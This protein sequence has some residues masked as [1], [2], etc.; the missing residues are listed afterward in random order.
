MTKPLVIV[1]SGLAGYT[2][3]REFRKLNSDQPLL[4]ITADGGESYSKPMLS[5]AFSAGKDKHALGMASAVQMAEKLNATVL[6]ETS[7][8][9]IDLH[10]RQLLLDGQEVVYDKLVL[11]LGASPLKLE[12]AGDAVGEVLQVNNLDDYQRFFVRLQTAKSVLVIGSGL[13]G[14]EFANDLALGGKQVTLVGRAER[15]LKRLLPAAIATHLQ[16]KLAQVGVVWRLSNQVTSINRA[17][18][19]YAVRLADGTSLQ[20]DLILSALGL[21]ANTTLAEQ[22]GLQT[23]RAICVDRLLCSSQDS[24]YAL[25][26]CAQVDGLHLPFV[27]PLMKSA[28]VLANTLAGTSTEVVYPAMPVAVKTKSVP[29]VVSPPQVEKCVL[30]LETLPDGQRALYWDQNRVLQGFVLSGSCVAEKQK[31]VRVLPAWLAQE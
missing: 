27:L 3:A 13:V 15:P 1:G 2:V 16:Q 30:E 28:Q 26:D 23:E 19:G 12:C 31:W 9:A 21:R 8:R 5:N 29:L 7:V 14:C 25:G 4:M 20:V 17:A 6:T 10:R 22:A 24:V 18:Q 11:A